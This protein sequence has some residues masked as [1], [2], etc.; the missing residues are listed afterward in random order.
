MN[1]HMLP[2]LYIFILLHLP[3]GPPGTADGML[4]RSPAG[5]S[6]LGTALRDAEQRPWPPVSAKDTSSH[7][8]P[9]A[10]DI[11]EYPL[12][13]ESLHLRTTYR[14]RPFTLGAGSP[15]APHKVFADP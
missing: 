6:V 1:T 14:S 9:D 12:G 3:Q 7:D 11:A 4:G 5:R 8:S 13:A 15:L 2:V 10:P